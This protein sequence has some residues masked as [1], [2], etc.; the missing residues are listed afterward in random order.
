MKKTTPVFAVL[1][2]AF[3]A[4]AALTSTWTGAASGS[5]TNAANWTAGVPGQYVVAGG[6]TNGEAGCTAIFSSV[7][8][9][10]ATTIDLDGLV[11]IKFLTVTGASAP[12]Y[13]FG[14]KSTQ[15]LPMEG[16]GGKFL[17]ES[18]VAMP[19]LLTCR[20]GLGLQIEGNMD[21]YIEN[22]ASTALVINDFG[23]WTKSISTS[24][25]VNIR[26]SG[27]GPVRIAGNSKEFTGVY[28]YYIFYLDGLGDL[29]IATDTFTSSRRLSQVN[30]PAHADQPDATNVVRIAAGCHFLVNQQSG[31]GIFAQGNILFTGD[32]YLQLRGG[33]YANSIHSTALSAG[34]GKTIEVASKCDGILASSGSPTVCGLVA[35]GRGRTIISG[36]NEIAGR[37]DVIGNTT[38]LEAGSIGLKGASS[39]LGTGD[40]IRLSGNSRLLY[41]GTGE[42]TDREIQL[43][44]YTSKGGVIEHAGSGTLTFAS[45]VTQTA[46]DVTLCLH[47]DTAYDAVWSGNIADNPYS[48]NISK[49]GTG[50]WIFTGANTYSGTTTLTEGTLRLDSGGS[51]VSAVTFS[52]GTELEVVAGTGGMTGSLSLVAPSSGAATLSVEGSGTISVASLS[53]SIGVLNIVADPSDV[54]VVFTGVS[55]GGAPRYLHFNGEAAAFDADGRLVVRSFD[56]TDEI[57]ARG[58]VIP[59]G[60]AKS[61]GIVSAGTSGPITLENGADATIAALGQLSG[62]DAAVS[63]A[64]GRTLTLSS[65]FL[66]E[67]AADLSI[68]TVPGEG[69]LAAASGGDLELE[70]KSASS[71]LTVNAA[72]SIPQTADIVKA[73]V[74]KVC[75]ASGFDHAGDLV[76]HAGS[77]AVSN[78][79]ALAAHL[80][81]TGTFIKEGDESWRISAAQPDFR[82][83]FV[84]AGGYNYLISNGVFGDYNGRLVVTNGA[85]LDLSS[86]FGERLNLMR[87]EDKA[88]AISGEGFNG[89][90]ALRF[91]ISGGT[92]DVNGTS[93]YAFKRLSLLGD[94]LICVTN[95]YGNIGVSGSAADPFVLDMNGHS[96]VKRGGGGIRFE[97]GAVTNPGPIRVESDIANYY[98]N[99]Q[100]YPDADLGGDDSIPLTLATKSCLFGNRFS[101]QRRKLVVQGPDVRVSYS[102]ASHNMTTNLCNWAGPVILSD[103]LDV[104]LRTSSSDPYDFMFTLSGPVSGPG[105]IS[106]TYRSRLF[107]ANENNTFGG[108]LTLDGT[109]FGTLRARYPG[110][111]PD[112]SKVTIN[113]GRI[114]VC[115][116][117]WTAADIANLATNATFSTSYSF[118]AVNTEDAEGCAWTLAPGNTLS[119]SGISHEGDG[120][121]TVVGPIT[122]PFRYASHGGTLKFSGSEPILLGFGI[123][124][125]D[126]GET[127]EAVVVFEDAD[128]IRMANTS[129]TMQARIG[130]NWATTIGQD[131]TF[132]RIRVKNARVTRNTFE[133]S[134]DV[135]AGMVVGYSGQGVL[136]V[137]SG[138]FITN[139]VQAASSAKTIGAIYMRGGELYNWSTGASSTDI[140]IRG[141]AYLEVADGDYICGCGV[142]GVGRYGE[143]HSVVNICGG[144]LSNTAIAA[145]KDSP[146]AF[147]VGRQ[148]HG[149]MRISQGSFTSPVDTYICES[150]TSYSGA[151][152]IIT[153][154]DEGEFLCNVGL[155]LAYQTNST[156]ILNLNGGVLRATYISGY[157]SIREG[158]TSYVNCSGGTFK[159]G[160]SSQ[161]AFRNATRVTLYDG[162]LTIDTG[163]NNRFVNEAL[164]APS[165]NGITAIP[166]G[167]WSV[168]NYVGSPYVEIIGSGTGAS[169]YA[170][171]DSTRGEVT[172]IRV[173]SPG[174]GYGSDTKAVL[175]WGALAITNA[176]SVGPVA[177]GGFTKKGAGTLTLNASNTYTGATVVQGGTLKLGCDWAVPSNSTI[178]VAAGA[179][180]DLNGKAFSPG[181][182]SGAGTIV[183]A[184][185]VPSEWIIDMDDVIAG[186][187]T[188]FNGKVTFPAGARIVLLNADKADKNDRRYTLAQMQSFSGALPEV[189]D[190]DGNPLE[191]WQ[192]QATGGNLRLSY[193]AGTA[194]S[195]R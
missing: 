139:L 99:I 73:G 177:G 53:G 7:A 57:A 67:D 10:A 17:V 182:V 172:A 124:C 80:Q 44:S 190:S 12:Q 101:P 54:S 41:V 90:G 109:Y 119:A 91:G 79:T 159:L 105:G 34:E 181:N 87:F 155:Q 154:E 174:C 117:H 141:S 72:L 29:E 112:A 9:G 96:L 83:D 134:G 28:A 184:T 78:A 142:T 20:L 35:T 102:S 36:V 185:T 2:A 187:Y 50:R 62:T 163:G 68:G 130:V 103:S 75:V 37:I 48:M 43:G 161:S 47:N 194:I 104:R 169:A 51:L 136:E 25:T 191:R 71:V 151:S 115:A 70:N 168:T 5:W 26:F 39:V 49:T 167:W 46:A 162:G 27:S 180:L 188:K 160:A 45:S 108:T 186:S 111:V 128:D 59:N 81:G 164:C 193:P 19:P 118:L 61:V 157:G 33:L 145:T 31:T 65:L 148:G 189:V 89:M 123:L 106:V 88:V 11:G 16:W 30:V 1:V 95:T 140:G 126:P 166:S 129:S 176:V 76:L 40:A 175:Y 69:T 171:F 192:L 116:P 132:G 4:E 122:E 52:D 173:V 133:A 143:S 56:A 15:V 66:D 8:Q 18:S 110:S 125:Q 195:F 183:G 158:S 149:H 24:P 97:K 23:Y 93:A 38:T 86:Q 120:T 137:E 100:L 82:G 21:T 107:L 14:K 64:N 13:T 55:A 150:G 22:N 113:N 84:L 138:A 127:N 85:T 147:I 32:G 74:G 165:G 178:T 92:D 170:D 58:G 77:F 153:V 179:T 6:V 60:A 98:S 144:R 114:A 42:T 3:A 94:T 121:L 152:G 63:L 146:R 131:R 156:A 135:T